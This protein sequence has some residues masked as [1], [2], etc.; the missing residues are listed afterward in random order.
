MGKK[1]NKKYKYTNKYED[2][3]ISEHLEKILKKRRAKKDV[4]NIWH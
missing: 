3:N 2:F 4:K 1:K